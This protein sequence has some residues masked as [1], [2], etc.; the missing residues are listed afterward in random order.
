M[1]VTSTDRHAPFGSG[2]QLYLM[3][4][5]GSED[6]RL[7]KGR[8][9]NVYARFSPDSRRI[10][11]LHQRGG[12]NIHIVDIDGKNDRAVY[13]ESGGMASPGGACWSPD[14]K[15]LAFA[16]YDWQIDE[17]G[18]KF[19]RAGQDANY[20]IVIIDADGKNQRELKLDTKADVIWMGH[21]QWR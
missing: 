8:G 15:Q 4:T 18:K 19:L 12:N 16:V 13:Q 11:Y 6:R 2:Y 21:S 14:G 1:F 10:A 3:R 17:N 20:R 5:D 9:L 7:T